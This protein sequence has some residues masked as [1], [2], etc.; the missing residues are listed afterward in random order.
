MGIIY[1]GKLEDVSNSVGSLLLLLRHPS[2]GLVAELIYT[3]RGIK[4]LQG[5]SIISMFA[6]VIVHLPHNVFYALIMR[7]WLGADLYV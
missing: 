6:S 1:A 3:R 4:T 2:M 5:A 7:N